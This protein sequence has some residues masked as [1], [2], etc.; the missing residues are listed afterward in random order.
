LYTNRY[1]AILLRSGTSPGVIDASTQ[2]F[3][4]GELWSVG[5]GVLKTDRGRMPAEWEMPLLPGLSFERDYYDVSYALLKLASELGLRAPCQV[6]CGIVG[7]EGAFISIGGGHTHGPIH[8]REIVCR[9]VADP[10]KP[11]TL[12]DVLLDFFLKTHDATGS[13]R[14][15][16]FN[17]FPP[18]RPH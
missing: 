3:E 18:D 1:G 7:I 8:K 5:A 15:E 13:A 16:G 9:K 14:P 11:E 4:N 12:N 10:S 6:E 17:A 2:L